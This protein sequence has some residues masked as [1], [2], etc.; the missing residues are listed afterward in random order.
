[1]GGPG[2]GRQG[3]PTAESFPCPW[4]GLLLHPTLSG[5]DGGSSGPQKGLPG[6]SED[7][8]IVLRAQTTL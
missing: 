8:V 3:G 2:T 7:W 5:V 1:M 4:S 6:R